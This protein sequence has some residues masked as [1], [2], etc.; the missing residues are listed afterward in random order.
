MSEE[1]IELTQPENS[2]SCIVK[3]KHPDS[4]AEFWVRTKRHWFSAWNLEPS[5]ECRGL[6]PRLL[7]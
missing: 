6:P 7:V 4:N 1:E 5:C 3:L 2:G